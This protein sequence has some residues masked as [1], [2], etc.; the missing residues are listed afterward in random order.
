M[1]KRQKRSSGYRSTISFSKPVD[2]SWNAWVSFVGLQYRKSQ[3]DYLFLP[4]KNDPRPYLEVSVHGLN[5]VGLLDSGASQ[6]VIGRSGWD[7]LKDLS[8]IHLEKNTSLVKVANGNRCN[9]LG[10]VQLPIQLECKV[11]FIKA[12]VILDIEAD[13]ILG[14]DFWKDMDIVPSFSKLSS[15]KFGNTVS[16]LGLCAISIDDRHKL[17]VMV[18]NFFKEMGSELGCA[19]GV[20]H[21]IDTGDALPIKQ[22][23]YP[24]SPYIQNLIN[25]EV[26][27]ML[28]LGVIEPSKSPWSSP[29]VMVKKSNNEY[30]FCIDFR[31][32]NQVTKK[33]AYPLPYINSILDGLRDAKVLSS[34]DLKSAYH[35]IPLD[36]SSKEKTAF[37][38]PGK[39]L[40]QFTRMP[41]GLHNAPATMQRLVDTVI[42]YDLEGSVFIYLD[43]IIIATKDFSTHLNV[44]EKVFSRLLTAGLTVNKEKCEFVKSE[45]KFLGYVVDKHGLRTDPSKVESMVNYPIP[46]CVKDVRRFVG[47]ISWYRRFVHNFAS[48]VS[49]LSKLTRKNTKF[50]W[51]SEAEVSFLKVK[52]LLVSAPI[53]ARPDFSR[54]FVLQCDASQVALSCVLTQN[55]DDGEH[56]IAYASRA[57]TTQESK[58]SS[59]EIECL[60]VLW[61]IQKYRCYVEGVR[62]KVITDH[63]SLLWIHKLQNPSGRLARWSLQLQ[64]FDFE[65]IHRKGKSHVVPDALSRAIA[66]VDVSENDYDDWYRNLLEKIQSN[67]QKYPK[68]RTREGKIYKLVKSTFSLNEDHDWKLVVPKSLRNAVFLENHDAPNSGHLG[69]FKTRKRIAMWYY[70]PKMGCDVARYVS[71]CEVCKAQ[72]PEQKLP[73][74]VMNK[75]VISHPWEVICTDF[76]GPLPIS[77]KRNR[78][79]FVVA[80]LFTKY[81]LLFPVKSATSQAV[82]D[83]MEKHVFMVYGVPERVI[84]DNGRQYV[85]NQFRNLVSSYDAKIIFNAN[86]HPQAN[87]TERVNRVI[88][89]MIRSYIKDNHQL[90]DEN[91]HKFGFALRTAVHEVTGFS[92]AYLNFGREL[93]SSGKLHNKFGLVDNGQDIAF[94]NRH[95]LA[96]HVA[97]LQEICN[98]VKRRLA[99]A[100]EQSSHR[101]NLRR[102][103]LSLAVDQV[104]WKKKYTQSDAPN[105]YASKLAPKFEKCKVAKKISPNVYQLK[106]ILSGKSLGNWHVKDIK[107]DK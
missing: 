92:P 104:V 72:K 83:I 44:L 79:I 94:D 63:Y 80:D 5:F 23:Y 73:Q 62:F 58:Y 48:L 53:L 20:L 57:L 61:G 107:V 86:Y 75:R 59:T 46:K 38:V 3:I 99:T 66:Y 22:R 52:E 14:I 27:K 25:L 4:A 33:D 96:S 45:L 89:T 37:T 65:I 29:I 15:W 82:V 50:V 81:V 60:A 105:Y 90:W 84:C 69:Y 7:K 10:L 106:D 88:K 35:Q 26:D 2:S 16:S 70:W 24:V 41:F 8:V 43:D 17:D 95:N 91:L 18:A 54:E 56:V 103:P 101:Y 6:T 19:K 42:G 39:G 55:F 78:F 98:I 97:E 32:V 71:Q 31:K 11:R 9:V 77:K 34:I 51:S 13:I 12:L 85:S 67:P 30:R 36:S 76:I 47:L 64:S 28:N 100:Y 40:F 102:R 1:G 87:P 93:I 49:P 74:G 21:S 68:W